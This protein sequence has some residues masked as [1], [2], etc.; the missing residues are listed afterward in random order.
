[1]GGLRITIAIIVY[2]LRALGI[3][4]D[5][6]GAEKGE[7]GMMGR[8]VMG[9]RGRCNS[10]LT[11]GSIL[12]HEDSESLRCFA[13]PIQCNG[14]HSITRATPSCSQRDVLPSL[15]LDRPD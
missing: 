6:G 9:P 7:S 8:G 15:C 4:C 11:V 5:D 2:D 1:M 12:G 14:V 3:G 10:L 13:I